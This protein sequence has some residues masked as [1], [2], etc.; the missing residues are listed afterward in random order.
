LPEERLAGYLEAPVRDGG[1]P[2]GDLVT[3]RRRPHGG[4]CL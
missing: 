4:R 3:P 2:P 1:E